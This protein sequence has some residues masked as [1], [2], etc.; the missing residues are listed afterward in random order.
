M[1]VTLSLA[2]GTNPAISETQHRRARLATQEQQLT[3]EAGSEQH[4]Q[5]EVDGA[6]GQ[7]EVD[8]QRPRDAPA[9]RLEPRVAP[10]HEVLLNHPAEAQTNSCYTRWN[11]IKIRNRAIL[12][13]VTPV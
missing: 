11:R 9:R 12:E 6:V 1:G 7:V 13:Q 2:S 10:V 5:Q 8:K 4:V 3:P